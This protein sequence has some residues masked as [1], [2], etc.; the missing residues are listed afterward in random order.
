[1]LAVTG[2]VHGRTFGVWMAAVCLHARLPLRLA[3]DSTPS[4]RRTSAGT[5]RREI[6]NSTRTEDIAY[7]KDDDG[8][9]ARFHGSDLYICSI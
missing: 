2:G 8:P 5:V 3:F 6:A 1:M 4:R 7:P 9:K